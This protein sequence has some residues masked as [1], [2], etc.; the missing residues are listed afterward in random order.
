MLLKKIY[1][2]HISE[3]ERLCWFF[4]RN[5]TINCFRDLLTFIQSQTRVLGIVFLLFYLQVLN[6][7]KMQVHGNT[8]LLQKGFSNPLWRNG[9][10]MQVLG[11]LH[12]CH[13]FFFWSLPNVKI[14]QGQQ[15]FIIAASINQA[16]QP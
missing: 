12:V 6:F 14:F 16:N 13:N 11:T 2:Y 15:H 4:G 9:S 7:L 10:L 1:L 8:T 3:V 5:E